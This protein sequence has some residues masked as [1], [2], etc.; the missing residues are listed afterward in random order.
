LRAGIGAQPHHHHQQQHQA[1][2]LIQDIDMRRVIQD[3]SANRRQNGSWSSMISSTYVAAEDEFPTLGS[4]SPRRRQAPRKQGSSPRR[5]GTAAPATATAPSSDSTASLPDRTRWSQWDA[6]EVSRWLGS[7]GISEPTREV[8]AAEP[9]LS[10]HVKGEVLPM[11]DR[12]ALRGIGIVPLGDQLLIEREIRRLSDGPSGDS[13]DADG[14]RA[15]AATTSAASSVGGGAGEGG[16]GD[17]SPGGVRTRASSAVRMS[18]LLNTQQPQERQH[19]EQVCSG[20]SLMF[21]V[22]ACV[23]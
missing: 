7:L 10:Q 2:A 15:V 6:K 11:L 9:F 18:R 8:V 21:G 20:Q 13:G 17:G 1:E 4:M 14:G 3:D 12:D 23:S 16:G 22:D 5:G 19:W